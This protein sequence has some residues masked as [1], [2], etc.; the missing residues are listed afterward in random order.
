VRKAENDLRAAFKLVAG[1]D[2]LHDQACY[3][4]QQSGEKFLKAILVEHGLPV[5]RIHD[6]LAILAP[7]L[8]HHPELVSLRRG[9]DFLSR[10]AVTIRYPGDRATRRESSACLRWA[11]RVRSTC[12]SALGLR[13]RLIRKP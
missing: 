4:C 6:L 10:F 5:R 12:R 3:F 11:E 7:I 8:V 13:H 9:L 1:S 2:P